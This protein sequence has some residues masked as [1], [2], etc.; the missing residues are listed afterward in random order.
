MQ[1][2]TVV[3]VCGLDRAWEAAPEGDLVAGIQDP[4]LG[5]VGFSNP[6]TIDLQKREHR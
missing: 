6:N 3:L 5:L 2:R 4:R 1:L